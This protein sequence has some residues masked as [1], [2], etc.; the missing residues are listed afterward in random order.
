MINGG[1]D[2]GGGRS[3]RRGTTQSERGFK[4]LRPQEYVGSDKERYDPGVALQAGA[5]LE[6]KKGVLSSSVK[7]EGNGI[8]AGAALISIWV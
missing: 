3:G 4:E 6:V 1:G 2:G 8:G 7:S 5:R